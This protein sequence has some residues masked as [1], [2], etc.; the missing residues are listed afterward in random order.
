MEL[1]LN[2]FRNMHL[3][4]QLEILISIGYI[5]MTTY[6]TNRSYGIKHRTKYVALQDLR[7]KLMMHKIYSEITKI[8]HSY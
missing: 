8:T 7:F 5:V 3:G 1:R 6:I 2:L 4:T